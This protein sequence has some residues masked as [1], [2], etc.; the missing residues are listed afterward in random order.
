M[1]WRCLQVLVVQVTST[2]SE[3]TTRPHKAATTA[4]ICIPLPRSQPGSRNSDIISDYT[5]ALVIKTSIAAKA[6]LLVYRCTNAPKYQCT[7]GNPCSPVYKRYCTAHE[8]AS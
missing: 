5:I 8:Q 4:V 3:V 1:L 6:R 2:Y 7:P